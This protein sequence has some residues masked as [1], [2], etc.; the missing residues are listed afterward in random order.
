MKIITVLKSKKYLLSY[1]RLL[2]VVG[3]LAPAFSTKADPITDLRSL[4]VFKDADLSK[5]AAGN[6]SAAPIPNM[7]VARDMSVQTAYV[8][9][10]PVKTT[11]GLLQQWDPARHPELRIYL[12]GNLPGRTSSTNFQ[13]LASVPLTSSVRA[14]VAATE[15]LPGYS[16]GL[17]Y[18]SDESNGRGMPGPVVT[19]WSQV[20]SQRV[21]SFVSGGL[22]AVPS[23]PTAGANISP[24]TEV[25]QLIESSGNARSYFSPMI[26]ATPAGGGRGSSTPSLSWQLFDADG[27]AVVSLDAFYARPVGDGYQTVD[28]GYYASGRYYAVV[29]LQQLWPVQV[30]GRD[31][32]LIWRVDLVSSPAYSGLRGVD[33]LGSGAA[34]MRQIQQNIRAFLSDSR[35]GT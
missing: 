16:S 30:D 12:Q 6:I 14:F 3:A 5:L 19:F 15:K 20:L 32:T 2:L 22:G 28:V 8:V 4:S 1:T 34:T 26:S 9:R 25:N 35:S 33:R 27:E 21:N 10:A 23:Y 31:A 18:T 13:S 11:V 24:A 7:Q 17:K 29:T